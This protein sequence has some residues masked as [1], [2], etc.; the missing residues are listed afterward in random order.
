MIALALAVLVSTAQAKD[1][2]HWRGPLRNDVVAQ[3]SGW[4]D[5][6]RL[7]AKPVW[8]V[9][10]GEGSTSPL[11]AGDRL[12]VIGWEGGCDHVRCVEAGTGRPV[13]AVAYKCPRFGRHAIGDENAYCGPTSTPE[14]DIETGRLY[15]LSCDGDLH[16][17]DA[18]VRG[19]KVW[20]MNLYDRFRAGQRPA[21]GLEKDDLRD[22]GYTTA[23]YVHGDW[24][25]V[26]AGSSEGHLMAFDKRTGERRWVSEYRGRAGHAGGLAVS[27]GKV[28]LTATAGR[29]SSLRT[30]RSLF[31]AI[32]A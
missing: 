12:Y 10:V 4:S 16:C 1:W 28:V 25:I 29:A 23:P 15:T 8:E 26:E 31:G 14:Y 18:R 32:A 24:L 5:G 22:Y 21:S 27:L 2:A 13:W 30:I 20:S 11:I 17:W 19:E 9:N 3:S 6:R 7:E